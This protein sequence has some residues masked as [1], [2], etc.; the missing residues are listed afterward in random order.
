MKKMFGVLNDNQIK[1]LCSTDDPMISPFIDGQV[2]YPSKGNG[3]FG[4]D[5]TLGNNFKF[6]TKTIGTISPGTD[7]SAQWEEF[8]SADFISLEPGEIILAESVEQFSIPKNVMGICFGKSTYCRCGVHVNMSPLEAGWRGR[9][10]IEISNQ[11]RY[12]NVTL[13]V[14]GGIAQLVFFAGEEPSAGYGEKEAG[15]S[16][17]D[18]DSIWLPK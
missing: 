2:G 1:E 9:L 4:Y 15:G 12:K 13:I 17:Q 3:Y 10:V 7:N 11:S 8:S 14:G 16:Y 18:Q 6:Q 5:I